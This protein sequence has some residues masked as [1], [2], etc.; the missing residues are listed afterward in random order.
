MVMVVLVPAAVAQLLHQ[1]GRRIAQVHGHRQIALGLDCPLSQSNG[2]ISAVGLRTGG[3]I[4]RALGQGNAAFGI[5][6]PFNRIKS[7]VGEYKG[8]RVR[9]ADVLTGTDEQSARDEFGVLPALNHPRQPV[10][11]PVRVAAADGLDEGRRNVVMGV[12]RLVVAAEVGLNEPGYQ[13]VVHGDT[14]LRICWA[15][16]RGARRDQLEDIEQAAPI[17][18][19]GPE[20]GIPLSHFHA[21]L[22]QPGVLSQRPVH[23]GFELLPSKSLEH[24]D[25]T[26]GEQGR[27]DFETGVFGGRSD[28]GDRSAFHRAEQAVLLGFRK[29]V[30]LVDEQHRPGAKHPLTFGAVNDFADV[31]DPT[32]DGAQLMKGAARGLSHEASQGGLAHPG[33]PPEDHRG[34]LARLKCTAQG[35]VC[36]NQVRLPYIILEGLGTHALGQRRFWC[37]HHAHVDSTGLFSG[38]AT[39]FKGTPSGRLCFHRVCDQSQ[40]AGSSLNWDSMR[41]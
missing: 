29:A 40:W 24:I 28:E 19:A 34:Q 7:R 8:G 9:M 4:G 2:R 13:R 16:C 22:L 25:L 5:A 11:R 10:D 38:T 27:D 30:D 6:E 20:Q 31:L 33:R 35:G 17:T 23:Q 14:P 15:F 32:S 18:A 1:L 3:Q 36:S 37:V 12:A 41:S 39:T 26:A 21:L